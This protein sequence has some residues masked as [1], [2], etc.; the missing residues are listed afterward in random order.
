MMKLLMLLCVP[1]AALTAEAPGCIS[2]DDP[3]LLGKLEFDFFGSKVLY[4][5]LGGMGPAMSDPPMVRYANV[6]LGEMELENEAMAGLLSAVPGAYTVGQ[7]VPIRFDLELTNLT[8][9]VVA[10]TSSGT[11]TSIFNGKYQ[12]SSTE[13]TGSFGSISLKAGHRVK[14]QMQLVFSC[15]LDDNCEQFLC[16]A[17]PDGNCTDAEYPRETHYDCNAKDVLVD[18]N[19]VRMTL[20]LFDLDGNNDMTIYETVTAYGLEG[21]DFVQPFDYPNAS[22]DANNVAVGISM[23]EQDGVG[24]FTAQQPGTGP[25][26]PSD[27]KKS[28]PPAS[29]AVGQSRVCHPGRNDQL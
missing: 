27:P 21:Y 9:Y 17:V 4:N 2:P 13:S 6:A 5:N 15:C 22:V 11:P 3:S 20:G 26:N 1:V 25:D 24:T 18:Q 28:G 19:E 7:K 23:Q 14:L 10:T 29:E 16:S 12:A 8:E